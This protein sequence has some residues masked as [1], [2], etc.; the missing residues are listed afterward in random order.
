[1]LNWSL[2]K[3][4]INWVT[5]TLMVLLGVIAL[6]LVLTPWHTQQSGGGVGSTSQPLPDLAR[7]Q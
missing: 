5:V 7:T 6:N 1:M 4:P 3:H 2:M